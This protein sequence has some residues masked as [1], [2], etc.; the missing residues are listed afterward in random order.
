MGL[1]TRN[2]VTRPSGEI[3]S[4]KNNKD[5]CTI[6]TVT[7]TVKAE[8]VVL[9]ECAIRGL[10][11]RRQSFL[12]EGVIGPSHGRRRWKVDPGRENCKYKGPTVEA[13]E[14]ERIQRRKRWPTWLSSHRVGIR[15]KPHFVK[16]SA[17]MRPL[18]LFIL[19]EK[20]NLKCFNVRKVAGSDQICFP[21]RSFWLQC[22]ERTGNNPE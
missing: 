7:S 22:K 10:D 14:R 17:Y 12:D 15:E 2:G 4:S 19:G 8:H 1:G 20:G 5:K 16:P 21:K 3:H 13:V 11:L 18:L 6:E 9:W